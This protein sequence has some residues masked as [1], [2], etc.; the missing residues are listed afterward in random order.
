[1]LGGVVVRFQRRWHQPGRRSVE[2]QLLRQLP[3]RNLVASGV[4]EMLRLP[5]RN[6][7][8][9]G[10]GD[11]LEL[12]GGDVFQRRRRILHRLPGR[13]VLGR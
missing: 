6:V 13:I 12:L 9:L 5:C 8:G 10:R 7:L 2:R 11:V 4:L 3:A 1:M